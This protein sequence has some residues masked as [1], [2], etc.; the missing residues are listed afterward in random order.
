MDTLEKINK[1]TSSL[2]NNREYKAKEE[3]YAKLV[4]D[5]FKDLT[6]EQILQF[7]KI[8]ELIGDMQKDELITTY[9]SVRDSSD[10]PF[11]IFEEF[12]RYY[13]KDKSPVVLDNLKSLLWLAKKNDRITQEKIDHLLEN[14]T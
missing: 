13:R 6:E 10:I 7:D 8:V 4:Y 3:T 14:Y 5:F 2:K 11:Y 9:N 1:A 12:I